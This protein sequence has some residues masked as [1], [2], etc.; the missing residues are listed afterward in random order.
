MKRN[1]NYLLNS[2]SFQ[3]IQLIILLFLMIC[4]V[5]TNSRILSGTNRK[6]ED[7]NSQVDKLTIE[8]SH[9]NKTIADQTATI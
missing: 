6:V 4:F 1:L 5:Q 9:M 7:S 2:S 3:A 8:N